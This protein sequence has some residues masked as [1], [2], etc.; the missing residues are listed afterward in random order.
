MNKSIFK[1]I[2]LSFIAVIN[3]CK[4]LP[5][6][7]NQGAFIILVFGIPLLPL[8]VNFQTVQNPNFKIIFFLHFLFFMLWTYFCI[9]FVTKKGKLLMTD[10]NQI[11]IEFS[12]IYVIIA[13]TVHAGI[14]YL[15]FKGYQH[16]F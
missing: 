6:Q 3:L 2:L 11:P 10:E 4:S 1:V 13:Q 5:N 7:R 9:A 14:Q 12:I 15:I 16:F 8:L